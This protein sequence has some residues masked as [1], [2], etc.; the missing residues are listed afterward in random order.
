MGNEGERRMEEKLKAKGKVTA[1]D[2]KFKRKYQMKKKQMELKKLAAYAKSLTGS[3]K[4]HPPIIM[5]EEKDDKDKKVKGKGKGKD[6]KDEPK[7][8]EKKQSA[9]MVEL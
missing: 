2:I 1:W 9:K 4:M 6:G 7:E 5:K 3:D 8:E